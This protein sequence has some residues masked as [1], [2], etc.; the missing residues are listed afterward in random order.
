MN[1]SDPPLYF[2]CTELV[3][4]QQSDP[5]IKELLE[6][7]IPVSEVKDKAHGYFSG[8]WCAGEEVGAL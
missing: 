6:T 7:A 2:S 4:E 8:Q 3:A 5:S 1:L